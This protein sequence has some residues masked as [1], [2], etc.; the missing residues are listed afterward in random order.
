MNYV[1]E[2]VRRPQRVMGVEIYPASRLVF[3]PSAYEGKFFIG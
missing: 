1:I 3:V 2:G